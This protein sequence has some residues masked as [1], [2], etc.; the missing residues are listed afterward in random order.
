MLPVLAEPV[1]TVVV[2]R[3]DLGILNTPVA[4]G[5]A[6]VKASFVALFFMGINGQGVAALSV[7]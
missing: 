2:S 3:F 5:V 4:I 7:S 1:F 6:V